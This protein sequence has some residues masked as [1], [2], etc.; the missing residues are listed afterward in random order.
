MGFNAFCLLDNSWIIW[1]AS[2]KVVK[3][4]EKIPEPKAKEFQK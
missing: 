1:K 2:L 4:K 3:V